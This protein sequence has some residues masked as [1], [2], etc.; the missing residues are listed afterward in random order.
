MKTFDLDKAEQDFRAKIAE[1]GLVPPDR[2]VG[3]GKIH[4]IDADGKR[5]KKD[6]FYVYH[7]DG[8]PAGAW[9]D[10]HEGKEAWETWC[11]A[12]ESELDPADRKMLWEKRK[13][14]RIARTKEEAA[15]TTEARERA[16][17]IWEAAEPC[18]SHPYLS[19]KGVQS[20]GLRQAED[21]R[22]IMPLRDAEGT[23][24]TL[25]Y[26]FA[27]KDEEGRDKKFMP[28]G[29]PVG[30]WF[31]IG[32]PGEIVCIAEGYATAASVHAATGYF[33]LSVCD[34]GN[35]KPVAIAVREKYPEAKIILCGDDDWK[36]TTPP[37][38]GRNKAE[39]AA[40]ACNGTVALPDFSSQRGV[41]DTDFN[42][43]Q[44]LRGL[45]AVGD[46]ISE[47]LLADAGP[48]Q[49]CD[50]FPLVMGEIQSRKEGKSKQTLLSGIASVDHL[51]GGL[52][53]SAV[54]VVAALPS[55]GKT[56]AAVGILAHNAAAGVPCLLF[57]IEMDRV[58]IGVRFLSIKSRLAAVDILD[59][60]MPFGV[61][62]WNALTSATGAM[63]NL[64]LIVD[65][66]PLG[67]E[68]IV[69]ESHKWFAKKVKARGFD[70]GLIAIDY[71]GLITSD[72]K[73]ENRNREVAA[74]SRAVK[75]KIAKALRTP[76]LLVAQ[77]NRENAKRGG[78]PQ[79]T[80]LRDSGEI[81]AN[82]DQI[83]FVCPWPRDEEGL[84]VPSKEVPEDKWIDKWIVA[85]NRNGRT[86][87]ALVSWN[88]YCMHFAGIGH[89]DDDSHHEPPH[90]YQDRE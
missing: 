14:D 83:I 75:V 22:L 32:K 2:L 59:E 18:F 5:G 66:R 33:T 17:R 67:I 50:L 81:E 58:E 37:N 90:N 73:S 28:G 13:A 65:D 55:R 4:R 42:D 80:D 88:P 69:S 60:R 38:P 29:V 78:D 41:K 24:H 6:G 3:D 40:E 51:S 53:R 34:C 87:A 79:M 7:T 44:V 20:Y 68:K 16:R 52:R 71:L 12:S 89:D 11:A 23:V 1:S 56:A 63:E 43:L 85:K 9:G 54:T 86:G 57:S 62:E 72:E 15:R 19:R 39:E 30:H 36:T 25:Q 45:R 64:P 35:L 10:W 74:L 47:A 84:K 21:G 31:E 8:I 82:A 48:M 61:P 27:Q 77:L 46:C 26:I 49:A 76:V 70:M